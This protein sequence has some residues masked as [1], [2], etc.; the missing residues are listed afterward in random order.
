MSPHTGHQI[1]GAAAI[2]IDGSD[3]PVRGGPDVTD[4]IIVSSTTVQIASAQAWTP[5]DSGFGSNYGTFTLGDRTSVH[6]QLRGSPLDIVRLGWAAEVAGAARAAVELTATYLKERNAFGR[7][8][9]TKQALRHR[10]SELAVDA[11]GTS[12]LARYAAYHD[13]AIAIAS[14]V[15]YAA[16]SAAKSPPELHQ[17]AGARGFTSEFGLSIWTMRLEALR[18]DLGGV[19]AA[20]V[21]HAD[22][23]WAV[24]Q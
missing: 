3:G 22:A 20:A 23:R 16:A 13:D 5:V 21:A 12:V 8:L 15:S 11:A 7:P 9:S 24:S 4:V 10:M 19:R 2:T 1:E 6:W 17:I 18:V 14:A